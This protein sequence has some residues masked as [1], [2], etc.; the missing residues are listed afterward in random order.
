MAP[1]CR[2][3]ALRLLAA[4]NCSRGTRLG[5][6]APVVVM[7]TPRQTPWAPTSTNNADTELNP[8]ATLSHRQTWVTTSP[9]LPASSSR[10]RSIA[11]ASAPAHSPEP[12]S[13]PMATTADRPTNADD[14]VNVNSCAGT[15]TRLN[16]PPTAD[17][18]EATHSRRQAG[19]ARGLR[20]TTKAPS[21][22]MAAIV[23][24]TPRAGSS[25]RVLICGLPAGQVVPVDMAHGQPG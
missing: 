22:T 9:A 19:T 8:S 7:V 25:R 20:S 15:T 11:S 14:P 17:T 2:V 23:G 6:A 21:F 12:V 1:V 16:E 10:R 4:T 18:A 24:L 3:S 5:T 13:A